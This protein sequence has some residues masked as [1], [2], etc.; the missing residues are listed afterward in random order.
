MKIYPLDYGNAIF[1]FDVFSIYISE[2]G[3]CENIVIKVDSQ[4]GMLDTEFPLM[5][6]CVDG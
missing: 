6:G 4:R 1:S 2:G 5:V 3:C